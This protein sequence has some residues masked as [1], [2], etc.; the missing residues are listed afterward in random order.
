MLGFFKRR[1]DDKK[2]EAAI[3]VVGKCFILAGY[4][5]E[6]AMKIAL[7]SVDCVVTDSSINLPDP[8]FLAVQGMYKF[9]EKLLTDNESGQ[10]QSLID[11]LATQI[12]NALPNAKSASNE[13]E[14]M[15]LDAIARTINP[16][17]HTV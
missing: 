8:W 15:M 7:V 4:G 13:V 12:N 9:R 11:H 2:I 1:R 10:E 17:N 14:T 6:D 16:H 5:S 3:E